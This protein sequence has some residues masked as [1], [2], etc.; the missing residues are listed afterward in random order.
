MIKE[1][2]LV[3]HYC[4]SRHQLKQVPSSLGEE[5][6]LLHRVFTMYDNEKK[7]RLTLSEV[8]PIHSEA[9]AVIPLPTH[10]PTHCQAELALRSL[11]IE[12]P[13]LQ[14]LLQVGALNVERPESKLS[15]AVGGCMGG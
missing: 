3:G 9:S 11:H 7:N 1:K 6:H 14:Q 13:H 5:L 10:A 4:S 8:C 2:L 15:L 12:G